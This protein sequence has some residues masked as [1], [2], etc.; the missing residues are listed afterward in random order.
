[1]TSSCIF[2]TIIT[3]KSIFLIPN[4]PSTWFQS[5]MI[6]KSL[7]IA[8]D[9][10]WICNCTKLQIILRKLNLNNRRI[11]YYSLGLFPND[12][13]AKVISCIAYFITCYCE[14]IWEVGLLI[15]RKRNTLRYLK[16]I[17]LWIVY[18]ELE[19]RE[20]KSLEL[21]YKI[22]NHFTFCFDIVVTC[23]CVLERQFDRSTSCLLIN[24]SI[25]SFW[26]WKD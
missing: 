12:E 2:I 5:K 25:L 6:C 22:F 9:C 8:K 18:L 19:I 3:Q 11:K 17:N 24:N 7:G 15:S 13:E 14:R 4:S 1:L 20:S 23:P 26:N 16:S 10:F 21:E